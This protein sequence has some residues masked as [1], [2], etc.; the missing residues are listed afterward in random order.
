[1]ADTPCIAMPSVTT[2][3]NTFLQALLLDKPAS[4]LSLRYCKDITIPP[5]AT[6]Y[7]LVLSMF[8]PIMPAGMIKR[9]LM[10]LKWKLMILTRKMTIQW[11]KIKLLLYHGRRQHPILNLINW[12]NLISLTL[13]LHGLIHCDLI[14]PWEYEIMAIIATYNLTTES[15]WSCWFLFSWL[16]LLACQ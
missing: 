1:M 2:I 11:A 4:K 14:S 10:N 9:N 3:C 8:G 13:T 5:M 16:V 6:L 12:K 15:C 7:R